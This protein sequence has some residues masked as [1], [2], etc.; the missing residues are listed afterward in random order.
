MNLLE[1]HA[2]TEVL[3]PA[4][5][6]I[7][8][9]TWCEDADAAAD[10]VKR[11]GPS[12]VKAQVPVGHRGRLGGV[13]M[14][15]SPEAARTAAREILGL[16]FA[17]HLPSAVLVEPRIDTLREF[18]AAVLHSPGDRAP[19]V[20]FAAVS[21]MDIED[22]AGEHP[23]SIARRTVLTLDAFDNDAAAAMLDGRGVE[24]VKPA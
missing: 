7:P 10:A 18:Y 22:I 6:R 1:Y 15:D 9:G 12:V 13:R 8:N 16:S 5:I 17:G 20:M 14:A 21:G 24:R 11:L 4:G 23:E 19:L 3:S 2:K